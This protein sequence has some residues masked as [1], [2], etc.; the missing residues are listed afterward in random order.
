MKRI[1]A[2]LKEN[3]GFVLFVFLMLIFR[4]S[5]ADWNVVPSG[6]MKPTILEGDRIWVNKMAYDLHVPF[7]LI[8]LYKI[9]DPERGDIV[10]FDSEV[11]GKR[12]VKRVIGVPGDTVELRGNRLYINGVAARYSMAREEGGMLQVQE[13]I[14]GFSHRMQVYSASGRAANFGP[15]IVPPEHYLVLGDNRDN[16]ADSRFIGFV[17][18]REIGGRSGGVVISLNYDNYYLPRT[19]RFFHEF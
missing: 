7:T 15:V 4:S 6:S 18:R 16:S 10:V 17:P 1:L 11:A 8:S 13:Q 5:F 19:D 9:A 12:L 2:F 3:R 14:A